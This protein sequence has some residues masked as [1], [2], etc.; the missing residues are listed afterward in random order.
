MSQIVLKSADN[1]GICGAAWPDEMMSLL[2]RLR[3]D[4]QR[5][6]RRGKVKKTN[7]FCSY[8]II[9]PGLF[10]IHNAT[11]AATGLVYCTTEL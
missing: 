11:A 4:Q 10:S 6:R 1:E 8:C 3:R 7:K 9:V 5:R 2:L